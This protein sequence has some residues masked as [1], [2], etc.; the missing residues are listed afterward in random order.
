MKP[1]E[2]SS[3]RRQLHSVSF[4]AK[5]GICFW[6]EAAI[7]SHTHQVV[8]PNRTPQVVIP[9]VARNLLFSASTEKQKLVIP[10]H[11]LQIVIPSVA[12]NL[13]LPLAYCARIAA[14]LLVCFILSAAPAAFGQACSMCYSTSKA[15]SAAGQ[16]AISRGVL[17]LLLP[18]VGF[19]TLGLAL[20]I[21]YSKKRDLE[22]HQ[23]PNLQN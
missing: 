6:F 9:S 19:M 16:R 15:T 12:R 5:R 13:L 22:H 17:I 8:I 18:P 1:S 7:P 20:A 4:R 3:L 14:I 23:Y 11:T 21:R 10:N 2:H